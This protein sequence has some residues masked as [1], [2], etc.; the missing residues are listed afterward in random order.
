[1]IRHATRFLAG[2]RLCP[3]DSIKDEDDDEDEYELMKFG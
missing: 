1:M 3:A 2:Q